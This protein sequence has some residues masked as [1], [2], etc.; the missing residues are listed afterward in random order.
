MGVDASVTI[1]TPNAGVGRGARRA[2]QRSLLRCQASLLNLVLTE[3]AKSARSTAM[4]GQSEDQVWLRSFGDHPVESTVVC[5]ITRFALRHPGQ[6]LTTYLDY[7]RVDRE[8]RRSRGLLRS[9]FLVETP[10]VCYT[11]SLWSTWAAIAEFGGDSRAHVVAGNS[12]IGRVRFSVNRGPEIWS[13]KW[14]LM[15]VSRNLNWGD[16]DL[17]SH[18]RPS[19][20]SE[21]ASVDR[22]PI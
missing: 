18:V 7:R 1:R 12:A 22:R 11:L 8:A 15:A 9:A 20:Q 4:A 14:R 5:V 13:S 17:R 21:R 10:R 6:L 2:S 19:I 16:L 3:L